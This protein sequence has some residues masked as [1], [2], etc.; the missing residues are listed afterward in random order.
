MHHRQE[1]FIEATTSSSKKELAT[2]LIQYFTKKFVQA[3]LVHFQ[4][5]P[6]QQ[7]AQ[8]SKAQRHHLCQLLGE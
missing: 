4:F 1:F 8:L 2:I 5:N 3:L 7:L 6:H